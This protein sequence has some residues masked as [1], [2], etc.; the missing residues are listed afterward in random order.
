MP[1]GLLPRPPHP[2]FIY[3]AAAPQSQLGG[4]LRPALVGADR[5]EGAEEAFAEK[6]FLLE[7]L[8]SR[9][10]LPV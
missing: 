2:A 5:G 4:A 8:F 10:D 7:P 1:P 3:R 9:L 6:G